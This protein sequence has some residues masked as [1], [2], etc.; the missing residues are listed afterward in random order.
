VI[1]FTIVAIVGSLAGARLVRHIDQRRLKQ[2]FA[3]LV[4]GVAVYVIW[5]RQ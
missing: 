2:A 4:M 1:P 5:K 3:L